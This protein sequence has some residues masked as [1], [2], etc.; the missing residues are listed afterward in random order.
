MTRS[1]GG[2]IADQIL[3]SAYFDG[4]SKDPPVGGSQRNGSA[5]SPH[6]ERVSAEFQKVLDIGRRFGESTPHLDNQNLQSALRDGAKSLSVFP[7][8]NPVYPLEVSS[9]DRR[10]KEA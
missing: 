7:M 4:G 2:G 9:G 3:S 6:T 5:T 10:T 8:T 1:V